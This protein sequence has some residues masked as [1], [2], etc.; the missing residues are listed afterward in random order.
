MIGNYTL[1]NVKDILFVAMLTKSHV[2]MIDLVNQLKWKSLLKKKLEEVE[3][4]KQIMKKHFL[5]LAKENEKIFS[6]SSY[7]Q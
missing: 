5:T 2:I 7:I 6:N 1:V 3:Y 4:Y